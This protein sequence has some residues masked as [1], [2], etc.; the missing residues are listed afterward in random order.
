M[1][2]Y[3][4][5]NIVILSILLLVSLLVVFSPTL[6]L[7]FIV[8]FLILFSLK[9]NS[10]YG[11]VILLLILWLFFNAINT[12]A[13]QNFIYSSDDFSSYYNNYLSFL[14]SDDFLKNLT[15]FGYFEVGLPFLNFLLTLII[16]EPEPYKV[17]FYYSILQGIGVI[18]CAMRAA[19]YYN[20][21][22]NSTI[23]LITLTIVF[24]KSILAIQLSRQ[25]FSSIFIILY[26]FSTNK[27][28]KFIFLLSSVIFH[29]SAIFLL[30]I[31]IF[32]FK[33]RTKK[34]F[35]IFALIAT[36]IYTIIQ[37]SYL[38]LQSSLIN[39]PIINKLDFSIRLL[40]DDEK[41]K[42]SIDTSIL[43]MAYIVPILFL[44]FISKNHSH[45]KYNYLIIIFGLFLFQSFPGLNNRVFFLQLY[46][47]LG[48]YYF[49]TFFIFGK[50]NH[51]VYKIFI[52]IIF[53]FLFLQTHLIRDENIKRFPE[54]SNTPFYYLNNISEKNQSV[55]RTLLR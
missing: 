32:L 30:P 6:S 22:V 44:S 23:L 3:K 48:F 53:N 42:Q 47:F 27:K 39:Y 26:I 33:K 16:Q 41:V 18:Y 51:L 20:L 1:N 34:D 5:S 45:F 25:T 10:Y 40:R 11:V 17:K 15:E 52:L 29:S 38:L 9:N 14:Y 7:Y 28:S 31:S 8:S 50:S 4:Y 49:S 19:K 43:L 37:F 13:F 36:F 24:Y 55:D 54:Y 12:I 46:F 35:L 21:N 2:D